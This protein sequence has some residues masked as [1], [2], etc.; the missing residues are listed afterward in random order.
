[1]TTE[2]RHRDPLLFWTGAA[3][4]LTLVVVTLISIS[5]TRLILGINPWIKP[6]KF[7]T[8]IAIFLWTVAWF[9]PETRSSKRHIVSWTIAVAMAI[10]II[11]IITQSARG[12]TSHFNNRSPFDAMIFATMGVT[13][14]V[15]TGAMVLF[16][17]MLR[18][19]TPP[20]RAG[21]IWGVR[22][23]V[24]IFLLASFEGGLIVANNAHTVGAADGGPGL[25]FVNWSTRNGDL[26]IAHFFG[27]HALQAL[28]L[29]GFLLDRLARRDPAA[30]G[31]HAGLPSAMPRN[32]VITV[33]LLWLAIMGG[34]LLI[35]L[36]GRPLLVL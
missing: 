24:A 16:L 30:R 9:M 4:L 21:Y 2:L 12:T 31:E 35:A 18:R 20:S 13:I 17:W 28:P 26:R 25:P 7:L 23:G 29:L 8:S 22:L 14:L 34:L 11:C 36:Q 33:S 32:V 5:D 3:M 10:E 27:M 19:D 1:M 15:N 6:M